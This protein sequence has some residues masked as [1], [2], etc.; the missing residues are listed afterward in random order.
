M[1]I[2]TTVTRVTTNVWFD[3]YIVFKYG[4]KQSVIPYYI[5]YI[6]NFL[7]VAAAAALTYFIVSLIPGQSIIVFIV[8]AVVTALLAAILL[9]VA[10]C[11]TPEFKYIIA[12]LKK[13]TSRKK[14]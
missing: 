7:K 4:F 6:K 3:P 1:L 2:G 8:K 12:Q 10:F 9:V 11:S 13:I 5:D 14:S